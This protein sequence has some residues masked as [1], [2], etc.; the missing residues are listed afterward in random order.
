[1]ASLDFPHFATMGELD[2]LS[3]TIMDHRRVHRNCRLVEEYL[4][5]YHRFPLDDA[6]WEDILEFYRRFPD[7]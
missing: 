1:M 6:M 2:S 3:R 4:I 7:F 5:W